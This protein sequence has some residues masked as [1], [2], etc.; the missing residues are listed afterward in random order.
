MRSWSK[1]TID[2]YL[3]AGEHSQYPRLILEQILPRI[4]PEH[5]V[6]DI[7]CG[8]G[9]YALALAPHVAQVLALDKDPGVL[10]NLAC[11]A[12]SRRLGNIACLHY[13]WPHALIEKAD[14]IICALGSGEIMS[15]DGL[16]AIFA[17]IPQL[18]FLVAPG[19]YLSPFGWKRHRKR[20]ATNA[21]DT[22]ALLDRLNASYSAQAIS[23]DFGQPV[24]DMAEAAEFLADFL[25]IPQALAQKHAQA[26]ALPHAHGLYLPN[27]RNL[28][29]ITLEP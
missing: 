27:R 10:D 26:I 23:L 28:T 5:T 14:V 13:V 19:Q 25:D 29:L 11:L 24:R 18:V 7:G 22:L 16:K 9:V 1:K 15:K 4:S 20:P 17:L 12:D 3:R 21:E 2:W 8:P 6:L